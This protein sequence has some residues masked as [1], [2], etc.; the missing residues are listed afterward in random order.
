[1]RLT[2]NFAND[3]NPQ[4]FRH[5]TPG[6]KEDRDDKWAFPRSVLDKI[7][8]DNEAELQ[9]YGL[10]DNVGQF[11]RHFAYMLE[12]YGGMSGGIPG[13][14]VGHLR[15]LRQQHVLAGDAVGSRPRRLHHVQKEAL[16]SASTIG[17][18]GVR[19]SIRKWSSN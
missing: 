7:A 12:T 9:V 11:R 2:A 4:I 8:R 3:L 16:R 6:W 17:F 14:G 15:S 19:H 13:L 10:H 5:A 1:M 18:Y